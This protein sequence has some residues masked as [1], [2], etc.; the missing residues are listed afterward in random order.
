MWLSSQKVHLPNEPIWAPD[1]C[2]KILSILVLNLPI[3]STFYAYYYVFSFTD[4]FCVFM[5]YEQI[6]P[7]I[8]SV[9]I[10]SFNVQYATNTHSKI[11]FEIYLIQRF[12]YYA[13]SF[14][15]FSVYEQILSAY[16]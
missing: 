14:R 6:I 15:I 10:D 2:P 9:Q 7:H 5:V 12:L 3:Y 1:N 8:L 4:M 11:L 13:D 16:S